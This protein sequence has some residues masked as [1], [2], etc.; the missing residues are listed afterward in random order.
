MVRE[1]TN[2]GCN[3]ESTLVPSFQEIVY[4]RAFART[5]ALFREDTNHG[6]RFL[7]VV[8]EDT[9]HGCKIKWYRPGRPAPIL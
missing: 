8:R 1:D 3:D 4:G 2:H 7:N 5:I 6:E 9:N